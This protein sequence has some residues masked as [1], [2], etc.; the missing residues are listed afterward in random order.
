MSWLTAEPCSRLVDTWRHQRK[1]AVAIAQILWLHFCTVNESEVEAH[2]PPLSEST[3]GTTKDMA[4][5][6]IKGEREREFGH[7]QH[8]QCPPEDTWATLLHDHI[9]MCKDELKDRMGRCSETL[10]SSVFC[11][12]W[13]CKNMVNSILFIAITVYYLIDNYQWQSINISAKY[14]NIGLSY[15]DPLCSRHSTKTIPP[16]NSALTTF[17]FKI[18]THF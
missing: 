10:T 7:H 9:L 1:A 3:P 4:G 11:I 12:S 5:K 13:T 17:P 6:R 18:F 15:Y 14:L 2:H 8:L 16:I